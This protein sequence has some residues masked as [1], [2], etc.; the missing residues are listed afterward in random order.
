MIYL[1]LYIHQCIG[2]LAKVSQSLPLVSLSL[3]FFLIFL[4]CADYDDCNKAMFTLAKEAFLVFISFYF[5]SIVL[6]IEISPSVSSLAHLASLSARSSPRPPT[7]VTQVG[8]GHPH[9]LQ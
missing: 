4:Q 6:L 8:K 1:T 3:I 5:H 9:W 7:D 2:R